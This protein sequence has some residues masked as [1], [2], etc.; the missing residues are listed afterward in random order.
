MAQTFR[1]WHKLIQICATSGERKIFP[2]ANPARLLLNPLG[3]PR[4]GFKPYFGKV[5]NTGE[6]NILNVQNCANL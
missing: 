2:S 3:K 5:G 1:K 4:L 6:K